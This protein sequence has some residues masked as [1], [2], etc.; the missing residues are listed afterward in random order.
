MFICYT[1]NEVNMIRTTIF[2]PEEL[3]KGLRHL[4]IETNRSM[5]DLL[6]EAVER[7]Y[8]EDLKDISAAQKAWQA[9]LKRP[10][11]A[12]PAKDYFAKRAKKNV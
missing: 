3:H 6:R 2:L 4:A 5:A 11:K 8:R 7:A 12:V 10:Q 1:G 9:H